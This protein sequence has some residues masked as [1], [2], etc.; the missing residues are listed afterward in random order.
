MVV[1]IS[2]L[3]QSPLI[4]KEKICIKD[5]SKHA[6]LQGKIFGILFFV[7]NGSWRLKVHVSCLKFYLIDNLFN[8][9]KRNIY[10]RLETNSALKMY[11]YIQIL[12][13]INNK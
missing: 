13:F 6:N 8:I 5:S 2:R 7:T 1:A 4:L 10:N 9:L 11:Y 12:L 3:Y